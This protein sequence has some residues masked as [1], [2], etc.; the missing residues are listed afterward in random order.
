MKTPVSTLLLEKKNSVYS[1]SPNSTAQ[2]AVQVMNDHHIGSVVVVDDDQLVGIFTERDVLQRIVASNLDPSRT[3]IS[4]VMTTKLTTI[5]PQT[6][7]YEAMELMAKR[8]HRHLPVIED[9]KLVGLISIGDAT[10]Y[11]SHSFD[12]EAG[13]L[14]S[15]ISGDNSLEVADFHLV[16]K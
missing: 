6:E 11:V 12:A 9:G 5:T 16:S 8:R 3:R 14:W 2:D 4:Q 1:V 10:R 7:V 13:S 15:Y